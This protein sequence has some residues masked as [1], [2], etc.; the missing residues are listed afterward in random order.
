MRYFAGLILAF[1]IFTTTRVAFSAE[2]IWDRNMVPFG[3]GIGSLYLVGPI[4]AGDYDRFVSAIK[5]RGAK[6]FTLYVRSGGGNT[7]E[8]MRIGRLVRQLSLSVYAPLSDPGNINKA[9]CL[10]DTDAVGKPVPCICAS[11]CSL[12]WFAGVSRVGLEIYIHSIKYDE[13]MFKS[14]SP[15][16]AERMYQQAMREVHAYLTEMDINDKYYYMMTQTGSSELQKVSTPI[17]GDLGGWPP[18]YREWLYAKCARE[19][20]AGGTAAGS[21]MVEAE[22]EARIEAIGHLLNAP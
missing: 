18:S 8:A 13:S 1:V 4:A 20:K 2:F 15:Q 12:I 16:E 11:A 10:R 21:C 5:R 3:T 17:G 19:L 9:S 6:P 14:L 22:N 7:L